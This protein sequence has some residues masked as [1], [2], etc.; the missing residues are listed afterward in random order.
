MLPLANLTEDPTDSYLVAGIVGDVIESL[1]GL[2]ELAVIARGSTVGYSASPVDPITAGREL[3]A[4]YVLN[5]TLSR[6]GDAIR[7][8]TRLTDVEVDR[9]LWAGRQDGRGSLRPSG[10]HRAAYC[11][12]CPALSR[13][14]YCRISAV[15]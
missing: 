7:I 6:V 12:R 3:G 5:G 11:C 1:S 8:S 9:L 4:R 2:R 14:R 15:S 10:S 13:T